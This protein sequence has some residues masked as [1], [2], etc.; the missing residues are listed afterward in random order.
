[1]ERTEL[2]KLI[3]NCCDNIGKKWIHLMLTDKNLKQKKNRN[4]I[5]GFGTNTQYCNVLHGAQ[6]QG[7]QREEVLPI[8]IDTLTK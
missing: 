4:F 8:I 2:N 7:H 5:R 6:A 3:E 1:M